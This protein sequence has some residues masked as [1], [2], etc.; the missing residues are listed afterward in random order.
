MTSLSCS[1]LSVTWNTWSWPGGGQSRVVVWWTWHVH[2][3]KVSSIEVILGGERMAFDVQSLPFSVLH[4]DTPSSS[5][6]SCFTSEGSPL[7]KQ[8]RE[9]SAL[10]WRFHFSRGIGIGNWYLWSSYYTWHCFSHPAFTSP[11]IFTARLWCGSYHKPHFRGKQWG[12][13]KGT[14]A[15]LRSSTCP[16]SSGHGKTAMET[17]SFPRGVLRPVDWT[18]GF[19]HSPVALPTQTFKK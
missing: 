17:V 13:W 8:M 16:W 3:S 15:C 6:R 10:L 19:R 12:H 5:W 7:G 9:V 1:V 2:P 18:W 11:W 4:L 14:L